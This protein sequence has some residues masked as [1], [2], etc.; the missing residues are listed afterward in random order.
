[1]QIETLKVFCDLVESR[2]FSRAAV[3]NSITQSAVSQQVK[4]L[5]ARYETQLLRRN[6]KMVVPTP[7]GRIFYERSRAILDSFENMQLEL[8]SIN[9]DM[10]GRVRIAAIY[11]VGLYEISKVVK[12]FLRIYPKVNLHV[13]YTKGSR[14][15]EDCLEGT[16][17]LGIVTY[18]ERR[19][20]LRIIPLPADKL[21]LIC[22]PDHPFAKRHSIDIRKLNGQDY[23]AF[24]KRIASQRALDKIF[25]AN[26]TQ[27]HVVMEFDNIE[28][29]KRSVEIGAGISI[30]PLLTVQKEVQNGA[31]VQVNLAGKSFYRPLGII[32]RR[33]QPLSPA[34]LKFIELMQNP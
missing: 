12:T 1:M 31:L 26:R 24:E 13:E 11:S 9:P 30:V 2:S 15:Y 4:N 8:K 33:N 27:V 5:E 34:A 28:T 18:P 32:T 29:I 17:D 7:A 20:G 21:V 25:K 6:G 16:V 3:R 10:T 19:K 23:V 22:A 14:V